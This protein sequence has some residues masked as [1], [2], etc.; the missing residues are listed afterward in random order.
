MSTSTTSTSADVHSNGYGHHDHI[1]RPRP[2]NP[3]IIRK[4]S[5]DSLRPVPNGKDSLETG[6]VTSQ[7]SGRSTPV[8]AD[9][10]PSAHSLSSARKQ[11]RAEHRRR[12][13]PTIEYASRVSHFD[14]KSDYHDFQGFFVLFWIA[15]TIMAITTMLRN[16]KDTG[17]PMRVQIWHLFTVK[18]WELGVADALMVASTAISLPLQKLFRSSFGKSIGLRWFGGGMFIQSVYQVVWLAFWVAIP[19]LRDWTWTAQVFLLLHTM[20]LLMKMHSYAFYNGHLSETETR[21]K[22]LDDPSTA[23]KTPA[24]QYP[25]SNGYQSALAE[26]EAVKRQKSELSCLREDLAIELTSPMG[27][28]TYPTN[29][30]WSNYADYLCCPTLCYEI[31]YPRTEQIV[32]SALA[33]KILA[34]FGVI[35]LLTVISEEFILPVLSQSALR[36]ETARSG[37]EMALILAESISLLLWPFMV[38]FL[39]VFLV[40]FEYVLGAFAEITRF[41]DRHFYDDWWNSTDWLEFSREWNIPVHHFF[42]RHVYSASRPHIGR[43]MATLITFLISAIGHEIVMAC[44]TK[45]IRGYGFLA[46][47]SQLP[48]VMI[49]RTKW[50][51]SKRILNNVCFWCS[52]ILGL[53]MICS[54]Y[55]LC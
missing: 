23:D 40:I 33:S 14:P 25:N 17:Y 10:P 31:E 28:V 45:K 34:T 26:K 1:L 19:F 43:P 36:L 15:L 27:S 24:Y 52:M 22:A 51:K 41:S 30:T 11:I 9:A 46:Q 47:M 7:T 4:V 50:V 53:S 2:I 21:L 13:F 55:V 35:F 49:Q 37:G 16:I 54:L 12:L 20:V 38:T 32:W 18:V 8:P 6:S 44:I 29:L 5:E 39:L 3:V 42:R 48:I